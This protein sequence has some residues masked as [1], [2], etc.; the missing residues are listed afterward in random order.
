[1]SLR[2][3]DKTAPDELTMKGAMLVRVRGMSPDERVA[4]GWQDHPDDVPCAEYDNGAVLYPACARC[5]GPGTM[6]ASYAGQRWGINPSG[7]PYERAAD[8]RSIPRWVYLAV[9]VAVLVAALAVAGIATF[10]SVNQD[11]RSQLQHELRIMREQRAVM[12]RQLENQ[13]EIQRLVRG[14][15]RDLE[16]LVDD[17]GGKLDTALRNQERLKQNDEALKRLLAR[18]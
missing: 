7:E 6:Y 16:K 11:Q 10:T 17:V 9:T 18:R 13:R 14:N 2:H 3:Q 12:A 8:R 1:M 15:Q 4:E 5:N